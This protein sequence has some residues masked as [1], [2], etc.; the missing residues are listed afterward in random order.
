MDAA[1]SYVVEP[2]MS[3]LAQ[4]VSGVPGMIIPGLFALAACLC[5][6]A[7]LDDVTDG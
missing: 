2:L 7:W 5:V 6:C 1:T 4:L 3:L